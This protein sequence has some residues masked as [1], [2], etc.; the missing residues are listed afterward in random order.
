[1]MGLLFLKSNLEHLEEDF[2]PILPR[3]RDSNHD[4]RFPE[5]SSD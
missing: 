1:M 3:V 4:V 2:E 5:D